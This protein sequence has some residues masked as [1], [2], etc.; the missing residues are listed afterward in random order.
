M[1]LH[2]DIHVSV[3]IT[4]FADTDRHPLYHPQNNPDMIKMPKYR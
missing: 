4:Y 3:V 1:K 2:M